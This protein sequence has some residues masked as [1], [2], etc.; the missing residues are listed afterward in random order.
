MRVWTSTDFEGVWPVG[1]AALVVAATEEEARETLSL[2]IKK[3]GLP[4][5][6]FTLQEI[7]LSERAAYVLN[8]GD[9]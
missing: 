3:E 8:N 6:E 4:K 5:S 9:Y 2:A 7:E 1:T